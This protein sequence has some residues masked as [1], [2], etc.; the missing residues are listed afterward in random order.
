MKDRMLNRLQHYRML[1]AHKGL[2]LKN[3]SPQSK[4]QTMR[5]ATLRAQEQL[6]SG[7]E[8]ILQDYRRELAIRI[9]RLKGVSPLDKL[10]QGFSYVENADGKT[11][12]DIG[13][14][15]EGDLLTV[16]VKNGRIFAEAVR[17]ESY[18]WQ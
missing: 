8:H 13:D 7:M 14:V 11:V 2:Q 10:N 1:L 3:S 17:M 15:T 4:I 5:F 9:E 6:Q 12:T 16:Q 18:R